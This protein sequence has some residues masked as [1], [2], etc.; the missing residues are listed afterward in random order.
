MTQELAALLFDLDGTL[1]D[2]ATMNA[3]SY[4]Q[5]L[6]E[7]GANLEFE[8]VRAQVHGR[9]WR[10]FLPELLRDA[11]VDADPALVAARK[12]E[13]YVTHSANI[14]LN[15]G[16][17]RLAQAS[18]PMLRVGLV[19]TASRAN[20]MAILEAHCIVSLFDVIVTGDDVTRHKPDPESYLSAAAQLGLLPQA[21]LVF[22]DSEIGFASAKAAGM[23][24][25]KVFL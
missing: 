12:R 15:E 2:T 9:N 7:F 13:I 11:G 25:V 23:Q 5:A 17:L 14:P 19:T 8:Q 21:C 3:L 4:Q 20:V 18:R 24:T 6:A 10:Q 16:L 1:A 22:E